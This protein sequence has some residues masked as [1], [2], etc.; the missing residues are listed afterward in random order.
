[1]EIFNKIVGEER[2]KTQILPEIV[3]ARKRRMSRNQY[4]CGLAWRIWGQCA[5]VARHA[6][7]EGDPQQTMSPIS[8]AMNDLFNLDIH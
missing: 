7:D 3:G 4:F 1:M 2:A 5:R 6:T 8:T